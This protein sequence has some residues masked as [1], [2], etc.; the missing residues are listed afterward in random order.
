MVI[1]VIM[2]IMIIMT[3]M[4][5]M[6]I[7]V[8]S[9]KLWK[10]IKNNESITSIKIVGFVNMFSIV[11]MHTHCRLS[12]LNIHVFLFVECLCF[13]STFSI[14]DI[15]LQCVFNS[16]LIVT[17]FFVCVCFVISFFT[18]FRLWISVWLYCLIIKKVKKKG[19]HLCKFDITL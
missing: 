16:T 14:G 7:M 19:Y 15:N 18:L 9:F 8:R 2:V 4:I 3:I 11:I 17:L 13:V 6:V 5:I 10:K 12:I 1:R